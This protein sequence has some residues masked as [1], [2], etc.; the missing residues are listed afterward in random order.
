LN[1]YKR[2]YTLIEPFLFNRNTNKIAIAGDSVGGNMSAITA[3]RDQG[4][5]LLGQALLYPVTD[6][7]FDSE[8]Y[9]KFA[10]GYFLQRDGMKW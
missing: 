4:E 3:L 7:S 2:G 9:N 1:S 10:K 6:F 5:H 8:S